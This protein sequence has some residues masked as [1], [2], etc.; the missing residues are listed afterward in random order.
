LVSVSAA[1]AAERRPTKESTMLRVQRI[2][3][4]GALALALAVPAA[5]GAQ[6]D[7]RSPDARGAAIDFQ[8]DNS[9]STSAA[10]VTPSDL[11]SPD[12]QDAASQAGTDLRSPDV[13]DAAVASR[14]A[15]AAAVPA[16]VPAPAPAAEA[17][18]GFEWGDAGIGA[19]GM[20]AIVLLVVGGGMLGVRYRHSHGHTV[21][22]TH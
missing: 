22:P 3:V 13:R 4:I 17:S 9:P 14:P 7:L 1:A 20:L 11:R 8:S 21:F 2:S 12:V 19:A 10:T 6:Q 5:A 15:P 18:T 16:P